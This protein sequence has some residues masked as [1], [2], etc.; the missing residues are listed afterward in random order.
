MLLLLCVCACACVRARVCACVLVYG[1]YEYPYQRKGYT[2]SDNMSP[3][4][5]KCVAKARAIFPKIAG[6]NPTVRLSDRS[7]HNHLTCWRRVLIPGRNDERRARCKPLHLSDS[8]WMLSGVNIRPITG[9]RCF[10][11]KETLLFYL[12]TA[13]MVSRTESNVISQWN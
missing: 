6:G 8:Y 13:W 10:V 3:T 1:K 11:E 7:P 5:K 12:S 4:Y 9:C 2:S